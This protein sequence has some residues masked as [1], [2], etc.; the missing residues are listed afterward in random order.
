M[1]DRSI[2][3]IVERIAKLERNLKLHQ[4]ALFTLKQIIGVQDQRI[5]NLEDFM[6]KVKKRDDPG[7]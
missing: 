3:G 5:T 6:I 1:E 4:N 7:G 2:E